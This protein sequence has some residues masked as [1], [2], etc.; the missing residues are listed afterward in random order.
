M[1]R[2]L[3]QRP[4]QSGFTPGK[5][6]INCILTLRV[7]VERRREFGRGLFLAYIDLKKAFDLVHREL[8][9]EI[10]RLGGIPTQIIGLIANQYNG[11]D[12]ACVAKP[13]RYPLSWSLALMPF[14]TSLLA[15]SWGRVGR[16]MCPPTATP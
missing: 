11:L 12:T 1:A 13:G 16:T 2:S 8:L 4:E 10:L 3:H 14:V 15:G 9:W 5:F 6:T 7:I